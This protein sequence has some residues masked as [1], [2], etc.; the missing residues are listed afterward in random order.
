MATVGTSSFNLGPR[1]TLTF[2]ALV[3][4]ILGGNAFVVWQFH[5][6]RNETERLTGANQQLIAVL[7]L[8]ANL[9]SLHRRLDDLARSMD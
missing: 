7:Q 3:G 9:L 4:L 6:A 8:Q 5:E 1:L 2:A